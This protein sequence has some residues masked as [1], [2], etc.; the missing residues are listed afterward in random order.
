MPLPL[1]RPESASP[2]EPYFPK[3]GR[4]YEF[5]SPTRGYI[6]GLD[7]RL[8][9]LR[10]QEEFPVANAAQPGVLSPAAATAAR[11]PDVPDSGTPEARTPVAAASIAPAP[12]SRPAS[13]QASRQAS[14]QAEAP[15]SRQGPARV[16]VDE[17]ELV[18]RR[19][20]PIAIDLDG[21]GWIYEGLKAQALETGAGTV[22]SDPQG[23]EFLS[24]RS[25]QNRTSF[26]FR[27]AEYGQYELAFQL[28]DNQ[29]AELRTQI[30]HLRVLPDQEFAA[31]LDRQMRGAQGTQGTEP[32]QGA[33][34][35]PAA[36]QP[37]PG[38]PIAAADTLFDLG[39]YELA[40]IEYTRNMR[41]GDPYLN[42]RLAACYQATGEHLA[43]VK[44]YRE[45][46]GMEGEY[47]DRAAAGLARSSIALK[48]SLLLLEVLP[49]LLS[50]ESV[51]IGSELLQIAR[52]QTEDRRYSVAI[53]ALQEYLSRYPDGRHLDEVYYRLARVYEMD[54]PYRD[55][56]SA[57]HY[58]RLLYDSFPES[59]Y[60]D[61]AR[62]RLNYLNRHFFLV[63]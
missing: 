12:A 19:G 20:D 22:S 53:Q 21:S 9:E 13:H 50:Q 10:S 43:A 40:L 32:A 63:Q 26:S 57:R 34:G 60:V 37:V 5:A 45:N 58:Y 16:A 27:A 42:D 18:A 59:L 1:P 61:R 8:D 14:R 7:T 54:S 47:G 2:A 55:L 31:A 36:L 35:I 51:Q 3:H 29:R 24:R 38:P 25:Q 11:E 49:P 4:G 28:Q 30:V 48:D 56:E 41:S 6:D 17:R 46:L 39:E 62:E 23:V 44:Y 15:K 52:F 33:Q